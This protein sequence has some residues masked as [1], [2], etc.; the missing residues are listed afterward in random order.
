LHQLKFYKISWNSIYKR[1]MFEYLKLQNTNDLNYPI[2][3]H[4]PP[5]LPKGV[6]CSFL[7]EFEPCLWHWMC[8][9]ES[10]NIYLSSKGNK[11][12]STNLGFFGTLNCPTFTFFSFNLLYNFTPIN[13]PIM[14]NS[15]LHMEL[16]HAFSPSPKVFEFF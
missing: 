3:K 6:S 12:M 13:F 9:V 14:G 15:S 16:N 11:R 1:P 5:L 7:D 2:I 4:L 8:H 10:Y